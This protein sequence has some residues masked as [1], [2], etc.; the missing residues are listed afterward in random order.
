[1]I[2]TRLEQ[3]LWGFAS[4]L[5]S[6]L[7]FIFLQ[8][9]GV[10]SLDEVLFPVSADFFL[11]AT[12]IQETLQ[13]GVVP[14]VRNELPRMS[15][16]FGPLN[17]SA[18][19]PVPEQLQFF[20][21]NFWGLFSQDP[22]TVWN[23]HFLSGYC[24][25]AVAFYLSALYLRIR[26]A[27][28]F[29]L[30][31]AFTYLPF[32]S[33]RYEHLFL[34]HYWVLAPAS[35]LLI[36]RDWANKGG[37][38]SGWGLGIFIALVSF[39]HSYYG[40]F[41]VGVLGIA[42][43]WRA[44]RSKRWRP[45]VPALVAGLA[46]SISIGISTAHH[47]LAIQH[48]EETPPRFVR[49][50]S[51]SLLYSLRPEAVLLPIENHRFAPF[52]RAREIYMEKR[53]RLEGLT[54][55]IGSLGVLGLFLGW[56]ALIRKKEGSR[57]G[58]FS[59]L[60]FIFSFR[61]GIGS[62]IAFS[63]LPVFR[64]TNRISPLL[65]SV[66]L[67]GLGRILTAGT[68]RAAATWKRTWGEGFLAGLL[69]LFVLWDQVLPTPSLAQQHRAIADS[70]NFVAKIEETAGGG[71]V[72]QLPVVPFPEQP[73]RYRMADYSHATGP[74]YSRRTRWSYGAWKGSAALAKMEN[75]ER[76]L[77]SSEPIA[78]ALT[79]VRDTGYAG[80]WI[81][82]FGYAD[83]GDS[84][85]RSLRAALAQEGLASADGRRIYFSL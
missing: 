37:S 61:V 68:S 71:A 79:K 72:L 22:T 17:L 67:L 81:D 66:V 1:M 69:V 40:Y 19:F 65:A 48:S 75:L 36:G 56:V 41:V 76:E 18:L 50:P 43:V 24:L 59:L 38:Q 15:A 64:A 73:V 51:D 32:H 85:V 53:F 8:K 60:V 3:G 27:Y 74:L 49:N 26:P 77:E 54:E 12:W 55:S 33:L 34:S 20:A 5:A 62:I 35:A 47:F 78:S 82:R 11:I 4:I 28:A 2:R 9:S 57:A 31:I 45:L 83:D 29:A 52:R 30:S 46:F 42:S 10:F 44:I 23:L 7:P 63:V 6:L 25:A 21:L 70:K 58:F 14:F 16:P 39:W 84:I 13:G 80:I